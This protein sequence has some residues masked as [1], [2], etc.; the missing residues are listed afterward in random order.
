M[1]YLI[2]WI[3]SPSWS[4]RRP[5]VINAGTVDMGRFLGMGET[6]LVVSPRVN[7][8]VV[9]K[10]KAGG[11][12]GD[13]AGGVVRD[14]GVSTLTCFARSSG[15]VG[16]ASTPIVVVGSGF[17]PPCH[18]VSVVPLPPVHPPPGYLV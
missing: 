10:R 11:A 12:A 13:R 14:I 16:P 1:A 7:M 6:L 4:A 5:M 2:L 18:G 3:G 17:F 9:G 15:A 8:A